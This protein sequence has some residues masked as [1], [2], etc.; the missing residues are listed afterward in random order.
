VND[1]LILLTGFV[2]ASLVWLPVFV[3]SLRHVIRRKVEHIEKMEAAHRSDWQTLIYLLNHTGK[4]PPESTG[5]GLVD[6]MSRGLRRSIAR[7]KALFSN[8]DWR[9]QEVIDELEGMVLLEVELLKTKLDDILQAHRDHLKT[10]DY[11][12]DGSKGRDKNP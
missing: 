12:Q 10:F 1:W 4:I 2:L 7:L 3:L 8:Q 6:L 5:A 9:T 11:K